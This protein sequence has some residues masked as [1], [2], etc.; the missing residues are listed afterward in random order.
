MAIRPPGTYLNS[1]KGSSRLREQVVGFGT[2]PRS[3]VVF[4]RRQTT[5]RIIEEMASEKACSDAQLA[6]AEAD[7]QR[8]QQHRQ[9][10]LDDTERLQTALTKTAA[11]LEQETQ[12]RIWLQASV[13]RLQRK[14]VMLAMFAL[15]LGGTGGVV[16]AQRLTPAQG[17]LPTTTQ[18]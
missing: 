12:T 10:L 2:C 7:L 17:C 11:R 9:A 18:R 6:E 15:A 13:T 8:L 4:R 3:E 14:V 5:D 16:L 1:L